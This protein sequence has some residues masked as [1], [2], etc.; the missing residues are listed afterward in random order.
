[1]TYCIQSQLEDRYGIKMLVQLTDRQTPASGLVDVAVVTRALADTDA[2]INSYLQ[3]KYTLPLASTPEVLTDIALRVAIYKL[4]RQVASDKINDDY[5]MARDDLLKL[6][7]GDRVLFVN[8]VEV[9]AGSSADVRVTE[10]SRP[11]TANTMS[12]FI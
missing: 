2:E 10:A 11:F 8:N 1:L 5:K 6:S 12:G 3:G 4:H 9:P 7:K